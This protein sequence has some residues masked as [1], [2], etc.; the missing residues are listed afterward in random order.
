[1]AGSERE[2]ATLAAINRVWGA[3]LGIF[4]IA[5]VGFGIL[6]NV[7]NSNLVWGEANQYGQVPIP[8]K[9]VVHL[10]SGKLDANVA[11]ALP[12]RGN[13]TPV[14]R[15]PTLSLR[16]DPVGGGAAPAVE[17]DIGETENADEPEVDTKRRVWKVDV[18][19]EGDYRVVVRGDFTGYGVNPELW[20]GE[21]P[22]PLSSG[23]A[24]LLAALA[25]AI[26][27][28]GW[29]GSKRLRAYR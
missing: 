10:P 8:G 3:G 15:L 18:A 19:S 23:V 17:E 20:F 24:W 12:G 22:S 11:A 16:I 25:A 26:V 28:A 21:R 5:F 6:F 29:R 13:E 27:V 14:M 1:M 9:R 7:L 4:L 2:G